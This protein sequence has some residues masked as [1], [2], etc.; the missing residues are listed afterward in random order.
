M[1]IALD[2]NGKLVNIRDINSDNKGNKYYC[3]Y[4]KTEVIVASFKG[5]YPPYF[6][7]KN[8][9]DKNSDCKY[10]SD[11]SE[12]SDNIIDKHSLEDIFERGNS[13]EEG[14]NRQNNTD[15]HSH[16]GDVKTC[17]IHT[18]RQLYA[19]CCANDYNTEYL[20]GLKIK[21]FFINKNTLDY[22]IINNGI[23]GLKLVEGNIVIYNK[24]THEFTIEIQ[25]T[26]DTNKILKLTLHVLDTKLFWE[27]EDKYFNN[28]KKYIKTKIV[29]FGN[30]LSQE[31]DE[32]GSKTYGIISNTKNIIFKF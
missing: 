6:R 16:D 24:K 7:A 22:N 21:D 9:H 31:E 23:S 13:N 26:T 11:Y 28:F 14:N 29:V 17:N 19:Y 10:I 4:C 25:S 30:W 1:R 12:K 27:I 3:P 5:I 2:E 32:H 20:N 15:N 18:T 8:E